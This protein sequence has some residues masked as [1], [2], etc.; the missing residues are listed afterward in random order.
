MLT[1]SHKQIISFC[2]CYYRF[3][4]LNPE[5]QNILDWYDSQARMYDPLLGRTPT[6][7]S[8]AED[9]YSI[10]PYTWCVGNP[11]HFADPNGQNAIISID[12]QTITITAYIIL[13]GDIA[14]E[15][16]AYDFKKSLNNTWGMQTQYTDDQGNEYSINWNIDVR[17]AGEGEQPN[18]ESPVNNYL[19]IISGKDG[20]ISKVYGTNRGQIR[21]NI[22]DSNAMPHEFGH[23]L[24]LHDRYHGN[25]SDPGWERNI[26]AE[27][28]GKGEVQKKNMDSLLSPLLFHENY[29]ASC[30]RA[31]NK[32]YRTYFHIN[33][34]L[35]EII[36]G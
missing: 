34:K 24:G 22:K 9:Y 28:A 31:I 26:M 2:F 10:S 13:I 6:M 8:K 1:I 11:I 27:P 36:D 21:A 29:I 33:K 18:Y 16:L 30:I 35:R 32:K 15:K 4:A 3:C 17:I 14:T 23:I 20:Q 7:D 25:N 5:S 12:N 19:E